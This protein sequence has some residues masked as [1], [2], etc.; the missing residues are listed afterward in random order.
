VYFSN[1]SGLITLFIFIVSKFLKLFWRSFLFANLLF[2]TLCHW[3]C[4]PFLCS[5]CIA[6]HICHKQNHHQYRATLHLSLSYQKKIYE[7][8]NNPTKSNLCKIYFHCIMFLILSQNS[9]K[10]PKIL[11]KSSKLIV[12]S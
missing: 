3:F 8:K 4:F 9:L 7:A 11:W 2:F 5:S 12:P 1:R 6:F 10:S